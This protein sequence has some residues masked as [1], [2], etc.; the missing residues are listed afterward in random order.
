[1]TLSLLRVILN[2]CQQNFNIQFPKSVEIYRQ[3]LKEAVRRT[4]L[5]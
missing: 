5:L 4:V 2:S 3:E 1:M